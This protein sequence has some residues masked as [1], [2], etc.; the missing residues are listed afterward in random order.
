MKFMWYD[1][2]HCKPFAGIIAHGKDLMTGKY[3]AQSMPQHACFYWQIRLHGK[4]ID[5][6]LTLEAAKTRVC[7]HILDKHKVP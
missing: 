7:Q 6:A 1:L 5:T 4:L 3:Y 2:Y